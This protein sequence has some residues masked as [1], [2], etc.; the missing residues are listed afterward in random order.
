LQVTQQTADELAKII[1]DLLQGTDCPDNIHYR[2][3]YLIGEF[4]G[5]AVGG[6]I[7]KGFKFCFVAGTLVH[8][9]D[10]LKKIEDIKEGDEVLSYN[11]QTE[12]NEYQPVLQTFVNKVDVNTRNKLTQ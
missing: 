8:T 6:N 7:A 10:G 1:V 4:V 3:G 9:K 11:E 5:A 12:Q 2:I